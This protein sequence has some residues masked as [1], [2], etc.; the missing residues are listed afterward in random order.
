MSFIGNQTQESRR[1]EEREQLVENVKISGRLFTL[2]TIR[3]LIELEDGLCTE[4][5]GLMNE[6]E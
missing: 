3:K 1:E 2:R 6:I 5:P 4:N